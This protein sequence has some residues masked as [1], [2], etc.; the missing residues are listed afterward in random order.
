M[1]LASCVIVRHLRR[2]GTARVACIVDRRNRRSAA[3][4]RGKIAAPVPHIQ[5][6]RETLGAHWTCA[7]GRQGY[8]PVNNGGDI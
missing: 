4:S 7:N 1:K 3:N 8:R 2:A 6:M 5:G